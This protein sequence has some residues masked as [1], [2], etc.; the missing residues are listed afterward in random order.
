MV[1]FWPCLAAPWIFSGLPLKQLTLA[2]VNAGPWLD[3]RAPFPLVGF[4]PLF[5][6]STR[7]S[8]QWAPLGQGM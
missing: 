5:M 3:P 7:L 2:V 1:L 4:F 6:E 8:Q